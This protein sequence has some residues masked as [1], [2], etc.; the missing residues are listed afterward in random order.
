MHGAEQRGHGSGVLE[1][2]GENFIFAFDFA[3]ENFGNERGLLHRTRGLLV[4]ER[5]KCD[6][7]QNLR[8]IYP[9]A[10]RQ[11]LEFIDRR[12]VTLKRRTD[13]DTN[14]AGFDR[15]DPD[16]HGGGRAIT[17]QGGSGRNLID[18]VPCGGVRGNFD[19]Q[20]AKL[21]VR[22]CSEAVAAE[23]EAPERL[24]SPKV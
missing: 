18:F 23:A 10:C 9:G 7:G 13:G 5:T 4:G 20:R 6:G 24:V 3:V 8:R 16:F 11:N 14:P 2:E 1:A 12:S 19:A 22:E 21:A 17:G 15:L